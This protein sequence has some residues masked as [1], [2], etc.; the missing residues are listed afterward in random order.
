MIQTAV[1]TIKVVKMLRL[2][3]IKLMRYAEF[4]M[5]KFGPHHG[6]LPSSAPGC[7]LWE[8]YVAH[9]EISM[10]FFLKRLLDGLA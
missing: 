8:F 5:M 10:E 3:M 9:E 2:A 7:P 6:A 1:P 4:T